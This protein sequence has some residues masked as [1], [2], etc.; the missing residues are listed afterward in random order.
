MNQPS[1][2]QLYV[3]IDI[4]ATTFT[5]VWTGPGYPPSAP[6]T[7]A[8]TSEGF[9]SLQT[10]LL[11]TTIAPAAVLVAVEATGSYWI[12]LATTLQAAGYAIAVINPKQAHNFAQSLPRRSKTDALDARL[13]AQFAAERH[14]P[15]WTPPPARP[16]CTTSTRRCW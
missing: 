9:A 4:A 1:V 3:G 11:Q 13:L 12:R 14:P 16:P 7:L 15:T 2:F 8:Q 6:T 10:Q 5:A